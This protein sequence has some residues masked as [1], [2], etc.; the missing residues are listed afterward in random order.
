MC[1]FSL[2]NQLQSLLSITFLN[3]YNDVNII[4]STSILVDL[5]RTVR[6]GFDLSSQNV[7][8][9]VESLPDTNTPDAK[10]VQIAVNYPD[11]QGQE[12]VAA[13]L[14][15]PV[16]HEVVEEGMQIVACCAHDTIPAC[17]CLHC[18]C[19]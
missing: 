11:G 7:P 12:L 5:H 10:A 9:P 17:V 6:N 3:V 16:V 4:R 13:E 2:C 1:I 19:V 8:L 14:E 15:Q 18:A